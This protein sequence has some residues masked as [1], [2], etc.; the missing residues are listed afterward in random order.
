MPIVTRF[1]PSPTGHLHLG[2]AFSA[3]IAWRRA[4]EAGGRIGG[5]FFLRRSA[6]RFV[7]EASAPRG[8]ATMF[9][10]K[11][12]AL[13][14]PNASCASVGLPPQQLQLGLARSLENG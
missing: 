11:P 6:Y 3:L 9:L 7:Q 13:D 4:R 14:T 5:M 1:A 2:H 10:A 12:F 8:S